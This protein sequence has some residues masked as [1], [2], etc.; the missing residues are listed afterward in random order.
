V[1]SSALRVRDNDGG[2]E[3]VQREADMSGAAAATLSF[4]YKRVALD[5]LD[6]Y[7]TVEISASGATGPW[8]ELDRFEG[9]ADDSGYQPVSYDITA[10]VSNDTRIRFLS[11]SD[12]GGQD[13][14][15]FDNVQIQCTP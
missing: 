3:G 1:T 14:L 2:G 9:A 6:D 13:M 5:S 10:Y 7:V 4:D 11:S 15:R 12:L 8:T